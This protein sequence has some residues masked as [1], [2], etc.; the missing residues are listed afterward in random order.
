M[1]GAEAR[2]SSM[3]TMSRAAFVHAHEVASDL[4]TALPPPAAR[5][6][7]WDTGLGGEGRGEKGIFCW[8]NS[9]PT[10]PF[11][12][13]SA[14]GRQCSASY[15][16]TSSLDYP[17]MIDGRTERSTGPHS[18]CSNGPSL[19]SMPQGSVS[20]LWRSAVATPS[21]KTTSTLLCWLPSTWDFP[22]RHF[23]PWAHQ[24]VCYL[25]ISPLSSALTPTRAPL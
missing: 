17:S 3:P 4:C 18:F 7:V 12:H 6:G 9:L 11:P 1:S 13:K 5:C 15:R 19:V 14:C 20:R 23:L 16:N 22:A 24:P 2:R 8:N 21:R 25:C 10:V